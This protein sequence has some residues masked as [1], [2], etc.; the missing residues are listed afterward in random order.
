MPTGK[1]SN[2]VRAEAAKPAAERGGMDSKTAPQDSHDLGG[3]MVSAA[4]WNE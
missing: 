4:A 1:T 2:R 3:G